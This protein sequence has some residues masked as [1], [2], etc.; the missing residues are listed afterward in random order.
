MKFKK[1][2]C[3]EITKSEYDDILFIKSIS[4]CQADAEDKIIEY[5]VKDK[6]VVDTLPNFILKEMAYNVYMA[7]I[8]NYK[9]LKV[10]EK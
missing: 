10:V 5:L 8:Y 1:L 7:V 9:Y 2:K 6:K 4:T 3:I